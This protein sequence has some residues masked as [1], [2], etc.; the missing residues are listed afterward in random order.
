MSLALAGLQGR[1]I[2]VYMDDIVIYAETLKEHERRFKNLLDRLDKASLTIEPKKC[3]F[4]KKEAKVL[5]HIVGNGTIK[6]DPEK[7]KAVHKYPK[8]IN[9]KKVK[10]LLGFTGYFR[11]FICNYAKIVQ[12]L[13][14]LMKK[15]VEFVWEE[16]QEKAFNK[17]IELL[18]NEPVLA[19]PDLNKP[20]IVTTDASDYALGAILSQGEIGKDRPCEYASRCLKEANYDTQRMTKNY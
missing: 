2:E 7:I 19:A 4:L 6:T 1:E 9:A 8:P 13:S 10:Q 16:E 3:Q 15:N 12:P 14:K 18:C 5:G 20:F 11:R 17:L